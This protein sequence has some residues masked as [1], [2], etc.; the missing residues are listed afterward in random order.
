MMLVTTRRHRS[1]TLDYFLCGR[2]ASASCCSAGTEFTSVLRW[3]LARKVTTLRGEIMNSSSVRGFRPLRES[4]FRTVNTP[5]FGL[6][7]G[8]PF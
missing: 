2:R 1:P 8:S 3:T 5:K 4:L 6:L 7:I